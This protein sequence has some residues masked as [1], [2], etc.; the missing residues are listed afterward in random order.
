MDSLVQSI[1]RL[2]QRLHES[3]ISS[4]PSCFPTRDKR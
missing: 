2:Q 3:D 4:K 1:R